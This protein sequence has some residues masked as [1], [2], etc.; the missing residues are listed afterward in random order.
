MSKKVTWYTKPKIILS[1]PK[2]KFVFFID[3]SGMS[4]KKTLENSL[5]STR[6]GTS[7]RDDVYMLNGI[8]LDGSE[9]LTLTQKFN[10]LKKKITDDGTYDYPRKGNRPINL[11]NVEIEGKKKPFHDL[12][13]RF[14]DDLNHIILTTK[15]VQVSSGINYY[16][17]GCNNEN[18]LD[19]YMPMLLGNII[20]KYANFLN[21]HNREGIIVFETDNELTDLAKLSYVKKIIKKGF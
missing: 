5:S 7:I 20:T 3:E 2:D 13:D 17:Y 19:N 16:I 15:F 18:F 1:I 4:S 14:P 10:R 11:H 12:Y 9:H 21:D 6:K 8:I